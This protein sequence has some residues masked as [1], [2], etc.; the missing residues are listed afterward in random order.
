MKI[1]RFKKIIDGQEIFVRIYLGEDN[2]P[3]DIQKEINNLW[4]RYLEIC[5]ETNNYWKGWV[6]DCYDCAVNEIGVKYAKIKT[7]RTRTTTTK[8][9]SIKPIYHRKASLVNEEILEFK[10]S[11]QYKYVTRSRFGMGS[12]AK[13]EREISETTTYHRPKR[14]N[15][16]SSCSELL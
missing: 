8:R 2:S 14:K 5:T 13:T 9:K 16:K 15:N 11:I 10:N 1:F 12:R 3:S 4:E 6:N 7:R